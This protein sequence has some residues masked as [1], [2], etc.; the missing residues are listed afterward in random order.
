MQEPAANLAAIE[1]LRAL[2]SRSALNA[3]QPGIATAVQ[4]QLGL[5]PA[6]NKALIDVVIVDKAEKQA[7]A[8]VGYNFFSGDRP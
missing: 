3:R 8:R 5:R 7:D 6:S 2:F 4:Q 1:S